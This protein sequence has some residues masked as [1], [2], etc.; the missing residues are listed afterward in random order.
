MIDAGSFPLNQ[1]LRESRTCRLEDLADV[2]GRLVCRCGWQTVA[3][4]P[5]CGLSPEEL[6]EWLVPQKELSLE[7]VRDLFEILSTASSPEPRPGDYRAYIDDDHPE[8]GVGVFR[9][10]GTPV[11]LMPTEDYEALEKGKT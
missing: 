4:E 2:D 7:D 8:A 10:D 1:H 5:V 11:I 6:N 3:F 9:A